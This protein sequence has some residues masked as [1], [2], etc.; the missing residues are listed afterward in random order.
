LEDQVPKATSGG[1]SN[2]NETSAVAEQEAAAPPQDAAAAPVEAPVDPAPELLEPPVGDEVI[3]PG[4]LTAADV[5]AG[6]TD[7]SL[8]Q[9][10]AEA[11]AR[12]LS[13]KGGA[14]ELAA[15]LAGHDEASAGGADATA[16][17]LDV[18]KTAEKPAPDPAE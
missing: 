15:R 11:K 12:G 5:A 4:E 16:L 14:V 18:V 8:A 13:A 1:A 2:A 6:Y 9:L 3:V 7:L 10:R 17:A